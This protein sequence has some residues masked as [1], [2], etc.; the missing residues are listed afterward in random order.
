MVLQEASSRQVA[1]LRYCLNCVLLQGCCS[2]A[3]CP[4][5]L[6]GIPMVLG[7]AMAA[8]LS[9][10]GPISGQGD[11]AHEVAPAP[12][13]ELQKLSSAPGLLALLSALTKAKERLYEARHAP[14]SESWREEERF[15]GR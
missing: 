15:F 1:A 5:P 8:G 13:S 4:E 9:A 12:L 7:E 2:S 11:E 3:A 14:G 6:L 10:N